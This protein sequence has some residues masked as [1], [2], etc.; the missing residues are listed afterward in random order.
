[1]SERLQRLADELA[2]VVAA[3]R[4]GK[5]VSLPVIRP[6]DAAALVDGLHAQLDDVIARRDAKVRH[7]LAC[8]QGCNACCLSAV[9]VTDGEAL[10]VVEWLR[11]PEHA[12]ARARFEAAYPKWRD[13]LG[14]L[15]ARAGDEHDAAAA[16]AWCGAVHERQAMCAF[17]HDGACSI[18][19]V[20][21]AACRKAHAL[22][23]NANCNGGRVT[24]FEDPETENVY[25]GQMPTLFALHEAV[26]HNTRLDLLC[27]AV[28]RLLGGAAAGRNDPCPCG[29]GKKFK[30]C[31]GGA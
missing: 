4:E 11:A 7:R 14:E 25:D 13:A 1:M 15:I 30:K 21:P 9:R 8:K 10:A 18:Y 26:R 16:N 6:A 20:R 29:S 3:R 24:F 22:D 12:D 19:P 2:T 23:T 28:H 17:N 27:S 5:R 31:C